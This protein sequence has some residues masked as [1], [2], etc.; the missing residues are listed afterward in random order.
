MKEA[1]SA[2]RR[3]GGEGGYSKLREQI[4]AFAQKNPA[5]FVALM[6]A[7]N[8]DEQTYRS[9]QVRRPPARPWAMPRDHRRQLRHSGPIH[10]IGRA[11]V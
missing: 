1:Q 4:E 8:K 2:A 6:E 9:R 3:A 10:Q 5:T 11:H 7:L